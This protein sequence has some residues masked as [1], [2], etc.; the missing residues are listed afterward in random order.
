MKIMPMV[1]SNGSEAS[2]LLSWNG[3]AAASALLKTLQ[4]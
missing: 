1:T 3:G 2:S 4:A